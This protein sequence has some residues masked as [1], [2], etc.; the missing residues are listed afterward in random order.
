M[1]ENK[2]ENKNNKRVRMLAYISLLA[3]FF[4]N[5][6]FSFFGIVINGIFLFG[7]FLLLKT[8]DLYNQQSQRRIMLIALII[9]VFF[10]YA[11]VQRWD[12]SPMV[13]SLLSLLKLPINVLLYVLGA[14]F[15]VLS[16]PALL[17]ILEAVGKEEVRQNSKEDYSLAFQLFICFLSAAGVLTVC[18]R[19][20]FLY[21]LNDWY[22]S[23]CFFTVGKSMMNGIVPYRDLFEQK[24]PLLYLI[25]GFSWLFSHDTFF[26][27]YLFEIVSLCAF[28]FFS[29][30]IAR[31]YKNKEIIVVIPFLALFC[32]TSRAFY[33]GDSAEEFCLPLLAASLWF[34]LKASKANE[35]LTNK[36]AIV[37]GI[38]A[39]C[40][41]WIKFSLIGLYLGW[42]AVFLI[43]SFKDKSLN[44]TVRVTAYIALG[45]II[46]T[47]PHMIY[48]LVNGA[49][50]DWLG[51]YL[52]DNLFLYSDVSGES[53]G[54]VTNLYYGFYDIIEN[55]GVIFD[56]LII[57]MIYLAI[58]KQDR[59]SIY[60]LVMFL[61]QFTIIYV[62][63]RHYFYYS[64]IMNCFCL[65]G[66]IW[67][68]ELLSRLDLLDRFLA[69]KSMVIVVSILSVFMAFLITP[70][71]YMLGRDKEELPQYQFAK[72]IN[73]SKDATLLNYGF[74]DGG[75]YTVTNILPNH[76]YFCKVN[77]NLPEMLD[78]QEDVIKN[79]TSLYIVARREIET[80]KY[81]LV[82][83]SQ[84]ID[85]GRDNILHYYLYRLK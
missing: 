10:L 61:T 3:L 41:F 48:F 85:N 17:M 74:L 14:L 33:C 80:D 26:G 2:K 13:V 83:E 15:C 29:Y 40:V 36:E 71:R 6:S 75:F 28:L 63:G 54:I 81:E 11:F 67:L 68:A 45:V 47:I 56:L 35:T 18:S 22:D 20:S 25:H 31:L 70:N 66:M 46:S 65:F 39:G 4:L 73:E 62:G 79:G 77:M 60:V 72:I 37:I 76:R 8:T 12:D 59:T 58:R 30:R 53:A 69:R 50:S 78:E 16:F 9:E 84:S 49:V 5:F 21:P 23:N 38:L 32:C 7:G 82:A 24:G 42:Y 52:Y 55:N 43:S 57:G 34:F 51:V 64:L 44:K 27:V 19:C 1:I